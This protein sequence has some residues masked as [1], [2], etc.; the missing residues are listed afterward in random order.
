MF[1]GLGLQEIACKTEIC[2]PSYQESTWVRLQHSDV[3]LL[4]QSYLGV[5]FENNMLQNL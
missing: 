1:M 2:M 5:D 3:I 4:I